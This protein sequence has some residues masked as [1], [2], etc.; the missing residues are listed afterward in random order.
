MSASLQRMGIKL[1]DGLGDFMKFTTDSRSARAPGVSAR[2]L[3]ARHQDAGGLG[4]ASS[5]S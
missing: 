3:L 5:S 2:F 1:G 4:V